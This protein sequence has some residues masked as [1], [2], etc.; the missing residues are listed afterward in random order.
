MKLLA[1]YLS[2]NIEYY[3]GHTRHAL[4]RPLLSLNPLALPI[5]RLL[6]TVRQVRDRLD[7]ATT[8]ASIGLASLKFGLIGA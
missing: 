3:D 4:A 1:I 7:T 5:Y 6:R 2:L 8:L